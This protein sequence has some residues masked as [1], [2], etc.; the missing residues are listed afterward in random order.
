MNQRARQLLRRFA[1]TAP[2][3]AARRVARDARAAVGRASQRVAP[4]DTGTLD[5]VLGDL[6]RA[7]LAGAGPATLTAI[8]LRLRSPDVA[9]VLDEVGK[10]RGRPRWRAGAAMVTAGLG[11][12]E[13]R[14]RALA[15]LRDLCDTHGPEVLDDRQQLV[16]A[17]LLFLARAD[18]EL[19]EVL[20]RLSRIDPADAA[21][22]RTDL[23]NPARAGDLADPDAWAERFADPWEG[24]G[25]LRPRVQP[26]ADGHLF[27]TLHI[28]HAGA[29]AD[30]VADGPLVTVI[31]PAFRPDAGL[32]TA[33]R[34]LCAQTWSR[35]EILLVD[36]ASGPDHA[37]LL[38][39]A[40][41]LDPRVRLLRRETNGGSYLCRNLALTEARGELVTFHDAD[42][43]AHPQRIERQV[44]ALLA[45]PDHPANHSL[46]MRA[47]DDLTRQWLG[48]SAVRTNASSLLARTAVLREVGGFDEVRKSGD[49][50]LAARLEALTGR[51]LPVV[52]EILA[53]TRL[54]TTS[55]SRGDFSMG[56]ARAA[57]IAY[58]GG[59]RHWHTSLA[60]AGT[61]GGPQTTAPVYTDGSGARRR[62]FAAPRSYAPTPPAE[63]PR[64]DYLLV[65]D[66]CTDETA[67]TVVP[68]ARVLAGQGLTVAVLHQEDPFQLRR[69]RVHSHPDVQA[70][71]DTG[72]VVQVHPE[73]QTRADLVAVLTPRS[74]LLERDRPVDLEAGLL[75]AVA[76]PEPEALDRLRRNLA[77]WAEAPVVVG[78]PAADG[79][80]PAW[81]LLHRLLAGMGTWGT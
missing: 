7:A 54:R 12:P 39:E 15:L 48:Y 75:W 38:H 35:L 44:A 47:H 17:Q 81:G 64:F 24:S 42:D 5:P 22:L 49:S 36:D 23:L 16:L 51:R 63:P 33:V 8:G 58:Q 46:A 52:P 3:R 27:D 74:L 34:S 43:W 67:R 80:G 59:Y 13:D 79:H 56:W 61:G 30:V 45:D 60:G 6:A 9:A 26:A 77:A 11:G 65:A 18:R 4:P 32:L 1:A 37:P 71:V 57:R 70:L 53:V 14:A 19:T 78:D 62:R 76:P 21:L 10:T 69:R 40:A 31:V 29:G 72:T 68:L 73:E 50:E 55:L 2:G 41:A 25:L 28:A 20:P 66:L